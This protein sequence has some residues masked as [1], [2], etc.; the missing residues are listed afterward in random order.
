M[1]P[2]VDY[3][4]A[5]EICAGDRHLFDSLVRLFLEEHEG[6]VQDIV[7]AFGV[8]VPEQVQDSLHRLKGALR[9]LAA[10]RIVALLQRAEDRA[11]VQDL[12]EAARL[13]EEGRA[14]LDA[15][16]GELLARRWEEHFPPPGRWS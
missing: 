3:G 16:V 9:N 11:K 10:H 12:T 4:R 7:A 5:S 14:V 13:W 15:T 1:E 6:M 2:L 8:G